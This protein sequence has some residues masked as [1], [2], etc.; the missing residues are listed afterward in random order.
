MFNTGRIGAIGVNRNRSASYAPNFS[1]IY[2]DDFDA[3]WSNSQ[4]NSNSNVARVRRSS[5]DSEQ[6]FSA[7]GLSSGPV[8]D[9]VV[10]TNV[11]ALYNNSMYFDNSDYVTA[12]GVATLVQT[13]TKGRLTFDFFRIGE[14]SAAERL[15]SFS[16]SGDTNSFFLIF[17]SSTGHM[18]ILIREGGVDVLDFTTVSDFDD[19]ALHSV[20]LRVTDDGNELYVDNVLQS[21]TYS[22]G[23]ASTVAW[24]NDVTDLD[25][26]TI[27]AAIINSVVSLPLL[28]SIQ[29]IVIYDEDNS[30]QLYATPGDGAS[31][32]NWEDS[33]GSNNGTLVGSP[34]AFT[35]QGYDGTVSVWY[36]QKVPTGNDAVQSTA[37]EQPVIVADGVK[38][39]MDFV[40]SNGNHLVIADSTAFDATTAF[41]IIAVCEAND[42]TPS[43]DTYLFTKYNFTNNNRVWAIVLPS[44]NVLRVNFGDPSNGTFEGNWQSSSS[45]NLET[46]SII[47][48]TY[49]A[50][51][52]QLFKNGATISGETTSGTIPTSLFDSGTDVL[53]GAANDTA[54]SNEWDGSIQTVLWSKTALSNSEVIDIMN[55]L[56]L[57][58]QV[59]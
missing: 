51:T 4:L 41:T 45:I 43:N 12:N 50:G 55:K 48:V 9:F 38:V 37:A 46:K 26:F 57:Q 13:K 27:G 42:T 33:I 16:D 7:L 25:A 8:L 58:W 15:V 24:T 11:Q 44:T 30:T 54:P 3:F 10:P 31:A 18:R 59:Y 39:D 29:N 20:D 2:G 19:G 47:A 53:V 35:G 28:G 21:V 40:A 5:D 6:D 52:V 22:T 32:S 56:N 23:N 49:S 14:M 34:V 17:L 1:E 36:D